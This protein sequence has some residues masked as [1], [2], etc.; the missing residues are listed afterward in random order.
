MAQARRDGQQRPL[1]HNDGSGVAIAGQS[2]ILDKVLHRLHGIKLL[3]VAQA[4]R[5]GQQ[6]PLVHNDGSGVAIA[7]QGKVLDKILHRL[8]N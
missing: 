4:R 5:D 3:S 6:G 1:V 7:G 2:K 8:H